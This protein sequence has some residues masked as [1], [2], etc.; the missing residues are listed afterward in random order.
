MHGS[1][2]FRQFRKFG[3]GLLCFV[4][5]ACFVELI[6]I[7]YPQEMRTFC[8][9]ASNNALETSPLKRM[10][11]HPKLYHRKCC[12]KHVTVLKLFRVGCFCLYH[13]IFVQ[14]NDTSTL[15]HKYRK[16]HALAHVW[17][18]VASF[19]EINFYRNF[20][21]TNF[22]SINFSL[23]LCFLFP[24]RKLVRDWLLHERNIISIGDSPISGRSF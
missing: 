8:E 11:R 24:L 7:N 4:F 15:L 3:C 13:D 9:S 21:I 20:S 6:N 23:L 12:G 2:S 17:L 5:V 16:F 10:W 19:Q 1:K 18:N 14:S 22:A